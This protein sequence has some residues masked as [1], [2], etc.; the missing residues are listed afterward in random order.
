[1]LMMGVWMGVVQVA[2]PLLL[3]RVV[4]PGAEH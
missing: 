3:L 4:H 1:M 2:P